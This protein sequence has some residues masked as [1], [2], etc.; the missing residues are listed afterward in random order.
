MSDFSELMARLDGAPYARRL[1]LVVEEVSP[2]YARASLSSL[3]AAERWDGIV[4]GGAIMSLAD[5]AFAG[6]CHSLGRPYVAVQFNIHFISAC[7]QGERLT[8]EARTV[9]QGR[10]LAVV[11]ITV[12]EASGR[13]IARATGTALAQDLG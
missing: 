11:D 4:H 8:A 7:R 9:H 6:A 3:S 2:G 12:N 5:Q 13:L 10:S 1:G